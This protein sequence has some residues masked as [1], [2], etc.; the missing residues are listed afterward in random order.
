MRHAIL[1]G[2]AAALLLPAQ[3]ALALDG[4][5]DP[6]FGGSPYPGAT[7]IAF[8]Q[9]GSTL[10]DRA[11]VIAAAGSGFVLAGTASTLN[12]GLDIAITRLDASGQPDTAFGDGGKVVIGIDLVAGGDDRPNTIAVDSLGRLVIGGGAASSTGVAPVVIRLSS[13][14][15][16]DPSWGTGG[17]LRITSAGIGFPGQG[18]VA[19]LGSD[20]SVYVGATGTMTGT[21]VAGVFLTHLMVTG[22]VDTT[23]GSG[24]RQIFFPTSSSVISI[25]D[26]A[27]GPSR[28]HVCGGSSVGGFARWL[29]ATTT[30][31]G[32]SP[33]IADLDINEVP[34]SDFDLNVCKVVRPSRRQPSRIYLGGGAR[35]SARPGVAVVAITEIAPDAFD[36]T[37][38]GTGLLRLVFNGSQ[39]RAR[40]NAMIERNS[41]AVLLGGS[42]LVPNDSW[43][44]FAAQLRSNGTLDPGFAS[45]GVRFYAG[46]KGVSGREEHFTG[47]VETGGRP[48]FAGF[49]QFGFSDPGDY[50]FAAV[51]LARSSAIFSNGFE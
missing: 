33:A 6:T 3:A 45:T 29:H 44:A 15:V 46:F 31:Q 32:L 20:N 5:L 13:L 8:D 47:V 16:P 18:A 1:W 40:L 34:S 36:N 9:P 24:G 48:V 42:I 38:A 23:F 50:D 7:T 4:D 26:L 14:G 19:R 12:G 22:A 11:A 2:L 21:S 17:I 37:F 35:T 43:E 49:F 28:L 41:G 39:S 25:S 51:A 10:D 27:I 30:L